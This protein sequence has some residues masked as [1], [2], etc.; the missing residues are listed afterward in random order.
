MK[1]EIPFK[2]YSEFPKYIGLILLQYKNNFSPKREHVTKHLHIY[3]KSHSS[4]EAK[5][6]IAKPV[7]HK[8]EQ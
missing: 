3:K 4:Y 2:Y 7:V 5:N 6:T 1:Y 8:Q